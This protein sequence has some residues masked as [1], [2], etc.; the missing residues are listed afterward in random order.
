MDDSRTLESSRILQELLEPIGPSKRLKVLDFGPAVSATV[1]FFGPY[2]CSLT[3][4]D[5][6][7]VAEP[8]LPAESRY[9]LILFWDTLNNLDRESLSSLARTLGP[10]THEHTRA[11]AF[12]AYAPK[13][14]LPRRSYGIADSSHLLIWQDEA[15]VLPY[16]H[17][18]AEITSA[19][20]YLEVGRR[21]LLSG[22]RV[23]LLLRAR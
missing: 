4:A 2:Q 8:S 13:T 5:L 20:P 14:R 16:P 3:F 1:S 9:D 23:E 22:E 19:F 18:Q 15:T 11:H 12:V 21:T 17:T 10:H 6:Y 7:D